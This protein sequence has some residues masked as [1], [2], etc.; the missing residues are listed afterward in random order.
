[1][2]RKNQNSQ[3]TGSKEGLGSASHLILLIDRYRRDPARHEAELATTIDKLIGSVVRQA[4]VALYKRL[5]SRKDAIQDL[6]ILALGLIARVDMD[7]SDTDEKKEKKNTG[8][9]TE[10]LAA[11]TSWKDRESSRTENK[12]ISAG[13]TTKYSGLSVE[14]GTK[15]EEVE[16][17]RLSR[18]VSTHIG[19][20]GSGEVGDWG[21]ENTSFPEED[22][23]HKGGAESG[24]VCGS[25]GGGYGFGGQKSS[26]AEC[27]DYELRLLNKKATN[28]IKASLRMALL[29]R[30]RVMYRMVA[31]EDR[32]R[33]ATSR[34]YASPARTLPFVFDDPLT[35]EVA[36]LFS[37][38]YKAYEIREELGLDKTELESVVER[39]KEIV[40]S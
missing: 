2:A 25:V 34:W 11:P 40:Q 5:E 39:I 1:M 32:E 6:R 20:G 21:G 10:V 9:K 15:T 35:E 8:K 14:G 31:R 3:S 33:E 38:G 19:F 22:C 23:A 27:S 4:N 18:R 17:G 26:L 13:E 28:Y 16:G 7:I 12:C 30:Y 36:Y 24:Q 37:E 29:H